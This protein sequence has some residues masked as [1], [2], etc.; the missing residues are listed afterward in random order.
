MW[1]WFW[2]AQVL[3][4]KLSKISQRWSFNEK[5]LIVA[6][7]YGHSGPLATGRALLC[8]EPYQHVPSWVHRHGGDLRFVSAIRSSEEVF[9]KSETWVPKRGGLKPAGKRCSA[10]FRL[11][12]RQLL[13]QMTSA[14][15]KSE[16]CRA[17]SAAQHSENC[18]ATG[19]LKEGGYS[20]SENIRGKRPFSSVFWISRVVFAP[21]GKG[22][23]RQKKGEKGPF[24]PI[25]RKGSQTPLKPPFVTPPFAAAQFL[26]CGML[27][28]W[29]LEG[30]GL[31]LAEVLRVI[32]GCQA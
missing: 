14:L 5:T 3:T 30:W 17:V 32:K 26:A 31:G 7:L 11:L 13:V 20:K 28:G 25:S 2:Y 8:R 24:G 22:R 23:K 16:C 19:F 21:S 18:S 10:V 4:L 1:L 9:S 12:Q 15:Y 6:A 29:G 27:Q